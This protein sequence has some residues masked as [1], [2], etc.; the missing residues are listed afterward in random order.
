MR[1]LSPIMLTALLWCVA[2]PPAAAQDSDFEV[3]RNYELAY[4]TIRQRI[5]SATAVAELDSLLLRLNAL[6]TQ[7]AVKS[8]FLDKALYPDDFAGSIHKLRQYHGLTYERV[9]LI[10][11]QGIAIKD[12]EA[13]IAALE[14]RIDTLTT[15]NRQLLGDLKA[16]RQS[17]SQLRERVRHLANAMLA[18]DRLI[19][20]LVDTIFLPYDKDMQQVSDV[21][22]EAI[23]RKLLKSNI[24]ARVY[25][26]AADN[27]KFMEAT[28]LQGKDFK[29]MFD[30]V[31]QFKTKWTGLRE[32][33]NAVAQTADAAL[34][35]PATPAAATTAARSSASG[36]KTRPT[37]ADSAAAAAQRLQLQQP[38]LYVDTALA[39]WESGLQTSFWSGVAREFSAKGVPLRPFTDGAGFT[40]AV[41]AYVDSAKADGRDVSVF[42]K[43][44]WKE[45]VDK[46]W[47]EVLEREEV[48]GKAQYASLDKM[49]SEIGEKQFDLKFLLYIVLAAAAALLIY[50]IF[51]R[52][53]K[54]VTTKK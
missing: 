39:Q 1:I 34:L 12:Y 45:K 7:Y 11:T 40:A 5:D 15:Q 49:V 28:Q 23:A 2:V 3:K 13:R 52:K 6:E 37:A 38:A 54:P 29:G 8:R 48:L 24:V 53:T 10:Q 47:R 19:F 14:A 42:V 43:D 41:Q 22:K 17:L 50:W 30:Q 44:V 36:K 20:A 18:R 26:I 25:D 46:E 32:K 31:Q 27:V 4:T 35:D 51:G 9:Y 21:Q 33:L 16:A